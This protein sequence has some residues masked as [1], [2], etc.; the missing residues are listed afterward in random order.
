VCD[1]KVCSFLVY[2]HGVRFSLMPPF[3]FFRQSLF[4]AFKKNKFHQLVGQSK[5]RFH[6]TDLSMPEMKRASQN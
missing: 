3:A 2:N 6:D 4:V 1:L 5:K